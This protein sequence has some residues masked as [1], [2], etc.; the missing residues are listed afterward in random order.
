VKVQITTEIVG[1]AGCEAPSA[2]AGTGRFWHGAQRSP[3]SLDGLDEQVRAVRMSRLGRRLRILML[4]QSYAP[5]IGGEERIVE[6][7]SRELS[8]RGHRVAIATLGRGGAVQEADGAVPIHRLRS[9]TDRLPGVNRDHGRLHAPPGPDP[10]TLLDLRRVLREEQPD[11]VHAHNWIVHSYLPLHRRAGAALVVSLH[12]YGLLC[13]TKRLLYRGVPCSGPGPLKCTLHSGSYYGWGRGPAIALATRVGDRRLRRAVDLFVPISPAVRDR[14]RLGPHDSYRVV[15]NFIGALPPPPADRSALGRLPVEPFVL[16]FGDI[17]EDKG[18]HHLIEAHRELR[19]RA[20]LVMIGRWLLDGP[21]DRSEATVLG[22]W[23]HELVI[24]AVRRSMFTVAPSVW[25]EP[26]GLV[27]LETAAAGKP[28]VASKIGGL[29]DIVADGETGILVPPGDAEALRA[30]L[31]RLIA[32]PPLRERMA[33]SA[34]RR[35]ALFSPDVIVPQFEEA[36]ELALERRGLG[37]P[38]AVSV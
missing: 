15:P 3:G 31:A 16:F 9:S 23:P 7:L 36:Y 10:E 22:P 12:D 18:A 21:A 37:R 1:V 17:S 5:I 8:E 24:E 38:S 30:A 28:I 27:A 20:P 33:G 25:P 4:T 29:N 32:D 11:I 19:E 35:A 14:C 6:D 13:A 26:F 34:V 2:A